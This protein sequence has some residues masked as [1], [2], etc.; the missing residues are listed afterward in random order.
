MKRV[1]AVATLILISGIAFASE[2]KKA[3]NT[4]LLKSRTFIPAE[5]IDP[6]LNITRLPQRPRLFIQFDHIPTSEEREELSNLNINLHN[7][8]H[9]NTWSVSLDK[10]KISDISKLDFVRYIG[11]ILPEDKIMPQLKEKVPEHAI[12]KDGTV[13]LIVVFFEDVPQD[14]AEDLL[15]DLGTISYKGPFMLNDYTITTYEDSISALSNENIIQWIEPIPPPEEEANDG[16]RAAVSA[17]EVQAPP[18]NLVGND[19]GIGFWDEWNIDQTHDDLEN[20]VTI[21][22]SVG[23]DDHATHVAGT[24]GGDGTLSSGTYRGIATE[25]EYYSYTTQYNDEE[26]EEHELAIDTYN[27]DISQNS[28]QTSTLGD[29]TTRSQKYDNIVKGVYGKRIPII[30]AA[31]NKQLEPSG[32][33]N[34]VTAP[35]ATAKNTIAVGATKSNNGAIATYPPSWGSSF[36]PTDDGRLKPDLMAPGCEGGG[37]YFFSGSS[38]WSTIPTDTYYGNCG[39]SMA[40]PVVSGTIALMWEQFR[41]GSRPELTP[42]PSTFKAILIQTAVDLEETG[43]DFK[44]GYGKI[45]ATASINTIIESDNIIIE[46]NI[47]TDE[48]DSYTMNVPSDATELK[49]TLVWDD[50]AGTPYAVKELIN[51]IDLVIV[52]PCGV[53]YFPWLLDS[54]N[55]SSP[56]TTGI[57]SLNNVEQVYVSNPIE[58]IWEINV[59]GYSIPNP[60]QDYSLVYK[61]IQQDSDEDGIPD[62]NDNCIF[63]YNPDQND[64]D[65]DDAGDICDNCPID[66]NPEQE[67]SDEDGIGDICECDAANINGINPVDF[68]DYALLSV[69][70]LLSAQGLPGDTNRDGEVNFTDLAQLVEHWLSYCDQ[71]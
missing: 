60:V 43:P 55:P 39:T 34:T 63:V 58:G 44:T 13:N 54:D 37:Y 11:P 33:F 28:W 6:A 45:N 20:R 18:Y 32:P 36:G 3:E 53:I 24:L 29:Y 30:F 26:P 71:P 49:V 2:T 56:A 5:G 42:L 69:D 16:V 48:V 22:E 23:A 15:D 47:S 46:D 1:L 51:D 14:E 64:I 38:I 21:A 50:V 7:Y 62:S 70:W 4:I 41:K 57:D 52:D 10:V 17:N 65:S 59:M 12:N 8:V 61:S 19:V 27:I 68:D 25:V 31:G 9:Y 40:A 67:D 66:Y 35:G